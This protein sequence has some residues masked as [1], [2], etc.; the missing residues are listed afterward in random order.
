MTDDLWR[1]TVGLAEVSRGPVSRV[2]QADEA[3]RKRIAHALNLDQLD[4][5]EARVGLTSWLDGA[6]IDGRWTA[7]IEQTC[8]VT[9][10]RFSTEL[11]GAFL[12]RVVPAGSPNAPHE[13]GQEIAVDPEGDDPPDVLEGEDVDIAGYVVE[14]L[15]LEIDPFPRKPGVEWQAPPPEEPESP[16]A[17]L[18][19]LKGEG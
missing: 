1:E 9:L 5:L 4:A 13:E 10:E 15:A 17:V 12:V 16:F 18:K 11:E 19:G 7:S 8:G 6:E 2:I 3:A 14:H